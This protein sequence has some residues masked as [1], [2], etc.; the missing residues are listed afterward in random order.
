MSANLNIPQIATEAIELDVTTG[1]P[2]TIPHGLGRQVLGWLVIWQDVACQ[3]EIQDPAADTT[4]DLVL[5][6]TA[7]ASVRVVLF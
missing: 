2:V 4:R 3:L 7:S 6:P 5:V 1:V